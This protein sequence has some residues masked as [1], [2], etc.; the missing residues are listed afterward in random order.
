MKVR[1]GEVE[2]DA[3]ETA[4]IRARAIDGWRQRASGRGQSRR[5]K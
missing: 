3:V 1:A 5:K 2:S 4:Q